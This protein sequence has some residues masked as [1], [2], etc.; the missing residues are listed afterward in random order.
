[1]ARRYWLMK[2]EP[3][4]YSFEDLLREGSTEWDGVRNYQARNNMKEMA[5]GDLVLIY[6]SVG[7]REIVGVAKVSVAAHPDS[8]TDDERWECVDLV[9]VKALDRPVS[10]A[11]IKADSKLADIALIRHSRLSVAPLTD[12]EF[13]YLLKLART[14]VT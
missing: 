6:H 2:T 3:G 9:P 10:L 14:T 8:T 4:S 11:T 13:S 12:K 7:P 1:M 5:V